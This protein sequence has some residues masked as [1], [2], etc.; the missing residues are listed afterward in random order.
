MAIVWALRLSGHHLEP[1]K[2][3]VSVDGVPGARQG[4]TA[5]APGAAARP[6]TTVMVDAEGTLDAEVVLPSTIANGDASTRRADLPD[7]VVVRGDA[8]PS[9]CRILVQNSILGRRAR[10]SISS[11]VPS[12]IRPTQVGQ[13]V[14]PPQPTNRA[15]RPLP[16]GSALGPHAPGFHRTRRRRIDASLKVE[17][18]RA[19]G[20][21]P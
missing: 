1:G 19:D 2:A 10:P 21:T 4:F 5:S 16:A 13:R 6:V 14:A 3:A 11:L 9:S 12:P 18:C 7:P 8:P 15:G 20:T 17:R